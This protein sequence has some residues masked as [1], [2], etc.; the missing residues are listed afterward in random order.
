[1]SDKYP[2]L[3][4]YVYCADNPV[5]LVDPEGKNIDDY[6]YNKQGDIVKHIT[7]NKPDRSF[8]EDKNG[9]VNTNWSEMKFRQI[10]INHDNIGLLGRVIFAEADGENFTS[11]IAVGEVVKN[12]VESSKYP[13]TYR[14][15]IE[16]KT[17]KCYQ[18]SSVDPRYKSNWRYNNPLST[19]LKS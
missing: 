1:M 16:Q 5:I 19:N 11:K 3:S 2:N 10:D 4:P 13:N 12:R 18:F 17:K 14:G 9:N 7:N 15:V 6:Y 8:I